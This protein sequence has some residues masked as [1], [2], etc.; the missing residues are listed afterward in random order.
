ML[1]R[2]VSGSVVCVWRAGIGSLVGRRLAVLD[3]L[4][5]VASTFQVLISQYRRHSFTFLGPLSMRGWGRDLG[6]FTGASPKHILISKRGLWGCWHYE[7][8][9]VKSGSGQGCGRHR[10]MMLCLCLVVGQWPLCKSRWGLNGT[11]S[12]CLSQGELEAYR[13]EVYLVR[14]LEDRKSSLSCRHPHSDYMM[15]W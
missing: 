15:S 9:N 12:D 3:V 11:L 5:R 8:F 2:S 14:S 4:F 6:C 13:N 10:V 1:R 7:G